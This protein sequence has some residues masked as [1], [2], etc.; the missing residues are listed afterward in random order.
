MLFV[1]WT[2]NII[3][4]CS[5]SLSSRNPRYQ[6]T[7]SH[8]H[9]VSISM[10]VLASFIINTYP[11]LYMTSLMVIKGHRTCRTQRDHVP[12]MLLSLKTTKPSIWLN[13]MH[14]SS[15]SSNSSSNTVNWIYW[16]NSKIVPS[17]SLLQQRNLWSAPILSKHVCYLT[18]GIWGKMKKIIRVFQSFSHI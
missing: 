1:F 3:I 10:G 15:S 7:T 17:F 16:K 9:Y 6:Y 5:S 18:K 13:L 2:L 8:A 4:I 14:M 12:C 11:H